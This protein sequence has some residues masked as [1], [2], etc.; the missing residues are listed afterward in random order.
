M[1]RARRR[2]HHVEDIGYRV[3]VELTR[4]AVRDSRT[5]LGA[6]GARREDKTKADPPPA[7]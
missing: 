3:G 5:A 4:L 2:Q 1:T 6:A 7:E